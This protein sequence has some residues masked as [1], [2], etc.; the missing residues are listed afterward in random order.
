MRDPSI[1]GIF[2]MIYQIEPLVISDLGWSLVDEFEDTYDDSNMS[3]LYL[4]APKYFL[5]HLFASTF[6]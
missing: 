6:V 5:R 2:S 1:S 4:E 3:L